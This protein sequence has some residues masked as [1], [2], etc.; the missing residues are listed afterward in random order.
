M[1][2]TIK[3]LPDGNMSLGNYRGEMVTLQPVVSDYA[4]GG[5]LVEGVP[6]VGGNVG[7]DKVLF[8]IPIGGQAGYV[9]VFNPTTSK[10]QMWQQSGAAGELEEVPAAT[11]LSAFAFNLLCVGY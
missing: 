4:T 2:Y 6:P 11:D 7:M 5:Y 3:I 9:P 8:V 10:V 1:A